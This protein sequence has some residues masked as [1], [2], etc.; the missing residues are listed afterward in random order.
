MAK[1]IQFHIP[2][3][4]RGKG[5][6]RFGRT[7]AGHPVAYTDDATAAYEN[8]VAM[9]AAQAMAGQAPFDTPCR[10]HLTAH[11]E[12]PRSASRAKR[13]AMLDGTIRPTKLP[14]LDNILKAVLDGCNRIVFTD[15][16]LVTSIAAVKLYGLVPGVAVNVWED[17]DG[18]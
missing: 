13:E 6:P 7:K 11:Y 5:R 17:G 16:K 8:L 3:A 10:I 9:A 14:D 2:G 15:D 18:E 1:V 12:T 4:P